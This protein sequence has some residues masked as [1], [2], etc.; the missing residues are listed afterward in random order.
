MIKILF[1]FANFKSRYYSFDQQCLPQDCE[2]MAGRSYDVRTYATYQSG[3]CSLSLPPLGKP[4]AISSIRPHYSCRQS[5]KLRS[6]A[7]PLLKEQLHT[8]IKDPNHLSVKNTHRVSPSQPQQFQ[9]CACWWLVYIHNIKL[10]LT[11]INNTLKEKKKKT[12][13]WQK[14]TDNTQSSY[15]AWSTQARVVPSAS[16]LSW[17]NHSDLH[18][19]QAFSVLVLASGSAGLLSSFQTGSKGQQ[20]LCLAWLAL[21]T[22]G[23]ELQLEGAA[24][25]CSAAGTHCSSLL[26]LKG[27]MQAGLTL[28]PSLKAHSVPPPDLPRLPFSIMDIL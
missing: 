10:G 17:V 4:T 11:S 7:L 3:G 28:A 2:H 22:S 5:F 8:K 26:G 27:E 15:T 18:H 19:M 20:V 1:I 21:P 13:S 16:F 12:A 14:A 9:Y 6:S 23:T 24:C 25:H